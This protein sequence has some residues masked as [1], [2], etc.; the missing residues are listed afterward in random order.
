MK[1]KYLLRMLLAVVLALLITGCFNSQQT[2]LASVTPSALAPK[3]TPS[4]LT[5]PTSL[6]T[7]HFSGGFGINTPEKA[8]RAAADGVQVAFLYNYAPSPG[9]SLE[10]TFTSLHMRVVDGFIASQLYRYQRYSLCMTQHLA[11]SASYANDT[12]EASY[13]AIKA[14]LQQVAQNGALVIGYWVL[15]DQID[16]SLYGTLKTILQNVHKLIEQYTP[17]LP[18]ICGFGAGITLD[19]AG[20]WRP[21]VAADFSTQGCDMVGL[22][23]YAYTTVS[24][25]APSALF[26]DWTM[27]KLLPAMFSSLQQ[28]GW[29]MTKTPFIGI[30]HAWG[31]HASDGNYTTVTPQSLASQSRSFC[32]HGATGLAFYG[33]T[34]STFEVTTQTPMNSPAIEAGIRNGITAC[35]RYWRRHP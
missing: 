24:K 25:L 9:S 28:Q 3:V 34:D 12:E 4:P 14:H 26:Y 2:P 32:E 15:D 10:Q 35:E 6:L 19:D 5:T 30:G 23:I 11:C 27:S 7:D 21:G 17:H 31:T 13:A 33:W 29:D 20:A 8:A 18:A 16:V 1:K 22:Y